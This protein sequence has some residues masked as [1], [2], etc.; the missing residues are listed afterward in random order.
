MRIYKVKDYTFLPPADP[1]PSI[2]QLLG[3]TSS[4]HNPTI[5]E[6]PL[7]TLGKL[8]KLYDSC[9]PL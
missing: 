4:P 8:M 5:Q 2:F 3:H 1:V 9:N 7:T 6:A